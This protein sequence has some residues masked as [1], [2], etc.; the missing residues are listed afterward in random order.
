MSITKL[1]P[2]AAAFALAT[3]PASQAHAQDV[4]PG[5]DTFTLGQIY[6]TAERPPETADDVNTST[7]D[8]KEI[9][10]FDR[11]SVDEALKL[12]P[13]ADAM[14][15]GG[16]RNE[17]L[18]F[19]R[20]F[21]RFQ[22]PFSIDGIVIYR[23][24]DNR[25]DYSRFLTADIAEL[26]V[27]KGYVSVL[28]GPGALGGAVNIVTRKPKKAF[29]LE[30]KT[31]IALDSY[32]KGN[33]YLYQGRIG[34][35]Q[36]R[37]Y[38]QASG[39]KLYREYMGMSQ[40]FTPTANED[41]G[42]R[43]HSS[44]DDWRISLKAGF[45]PN[46]TDEYSLTYMKQEGSREAPYHVTDPVS[47]QR[48]WTWPM[49][50]LESVYFLSTTSFDDGFKLKTRA[51]YNA[52]DDNLVAYD[53]A[54]FTTQ[55]LPKSFRS[56][57]EDESYGGGLELEKKFAEADTLKFAASYRR[58]EHVEWQ[59]GNS[60]PFT[61]YTEPRQTTTEDTMSLALENTV[62]LSP[63]WDLVL[64][65]SYNARHLLRAQDYTTST[66]LL[67]YDTAD[68]HSWDRQGA[69]VWY[70]GDTT[71]LHASVSTRTRF[72][73]IF[74][75]Y[76]SRFGGSVSNPDL[77]PERATTAEFG[78]GT[79][80]LDS[81]K[82][83]A[84]IY[85]NWLE[86]AIEQVQISAV[87]YGGTGL[88]GQSRNVGNGHSWGFELS[89][90]KRL[91]SWIDVG[92]NYAYIDRTITDPTDPTFRPTGVPADKGMAYA[93]LRPLAN[94]TVTPNIEFTSKRWT[95]NSSGT[96]YRTGDYLLVNLRAKWQVTEQVS[97]SLSGR[98]LTDENY[99]LVD[100][101]PSEGRSIWLTTSFTY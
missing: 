64:G 21:D 101:F 11:K 87:P 68:T 26:Q 34:T 51:F 17:A 44:T 77:K 53:D 5:D 66:G 14:N 91:A 13:S 71:K 90:E 94:V 19:V 69:L 22:V 39:A 82:L 56:Y 74:E 32:G 25:L 83:E 54:S 85:Y 18:I 89:A 12:V 43:N 84:A 2:L 78:V 100:G 38:L 48:N 99:T 8:A 35:K 6:V 27:A 55:N 75:R 67:S 46:A 58:D 4:S 50:S 70:P 49:S 9:E 29:E 60:A 88:V 7:V 16:P 79:G 40:D 80:T 61:P 76:S 72:P 81:L 23:P 96:Y 31:G 37:F 10:T 62:H 15:S 41:G 65:G 59:W 73:S 33:G 63:E 95:E 93:T 47:S 3:L 1:A 98:N 57:Y 28:N 20:G 45:T 86:D 52:F 30:A 92:A 97:L 42:A 36:K 24:A